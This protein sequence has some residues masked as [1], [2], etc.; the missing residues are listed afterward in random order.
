MIGETPKGA[1]LRCKLRRHT[2]QERGGLMVY[3]CPRCGG[4]FWQRYNPRMREALTKAELMVADGR[5]AEAVEYAKR[6]THDEAG[7]R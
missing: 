4:D 2:G 7:T 6:V 3:T 1:P 5:V